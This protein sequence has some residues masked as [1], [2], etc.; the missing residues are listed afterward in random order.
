M[1]VGFLRMHAR[2]FVCC[3]LI[4]GSYTCVFVLCRMHGGGANDCKQL[5]CMHVVVI[6]V[7]I[8][9]FCFLSA[10]CFFHGCMLILFSSGRFFFFFVCM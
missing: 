1:H 5:F 4:S 2:L 10:C 6:F 7:C 8:C 9:V 3:M